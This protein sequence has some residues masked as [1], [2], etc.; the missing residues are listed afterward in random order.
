MPKNTGKR[1]ENKF[2]LPKPV[3]QNKIPEKLPFD[4]EVV[5]RSKIFFSFLFLE[6][7][8]ELFNLGSNAS[9]KTVGGKWF[10]DLLDCLQSISGKTIQEIKKRPYCLHPINWKTSNVDCPFYPQAEW[11]QFRINKTRVRVIGFL[12]GGVFYVVWLDVHHNLTS[13]EGY[14]EIN[15]YSQP[16]SEYETLKQDNEFLKKENKRLNK[17]IDE[18]LQK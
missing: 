9:D 10:L 6:R 1:K 7:K 16:L 4:E 13:I 5:A 18:L 17:E 12:I 11:Y 15:R 8:H 14:G 2:Q 3:K